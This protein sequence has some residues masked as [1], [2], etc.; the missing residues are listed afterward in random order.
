MDGDFK[1]SLDR[2]K[3]ATRY[4][5]CDPLEERAKAVAILCGLEERL[6]ET[7]WLFG[8]KMHLADVAIL[9][10]IRQ[11]ANV[12]RAWFDG[13]AG[14]ALKGWLEDF[15]SSERFASDHVQIPAMARG[16]CGDGVWIRIWKIYYFNWLPLYSPF[17]ILCVLDR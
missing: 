10:F 17:E 5:D 12:D 15:E 2:Y 11:F 6:V 16:R 13:E 4:V 1:T 9:P 3:Y 7:G 8:S 14:P